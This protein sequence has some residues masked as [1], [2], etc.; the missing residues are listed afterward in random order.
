M[1]VTVSA[2]FSPSSIISNDFHESI[3]KLRNH[4]QKQKRNGKETEKT[5]STSKRNA[6]DR[7]GKE[8]GNT[9]NRNVQYRVKTRFDMNAKK[10]LTAFLGTLRLYQ[11]YLIHKHAPRTQNIWMPILSNMILPHCELASRAVSI[12]LHGIK[13]RNKLAA[14][15]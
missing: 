7:N 14:Q 13:K 11:V 3:T 1:V 15:Q 2:M 10:T 8:T 6:D 5:R 9:W 4:E 12:S